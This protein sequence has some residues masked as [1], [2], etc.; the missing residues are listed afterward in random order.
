ML[1]A[2]RFFVR[3]GGLGSA[4]IATPGSMGDTLTDPS[5]STALGILFARTYTCFSRLPIAASGRSYRGPP[6]SHGRAFFTSLRGTPLRGGG[7]A[8]ARSVLRAA[9]PSRSDVA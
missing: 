8:V 9:V 6:G 7:G 4:R 2:L 5:L 3:S 1:A